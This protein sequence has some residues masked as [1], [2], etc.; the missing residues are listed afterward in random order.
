MMM[1]TPLLPYTLPMTLTQPL[2]TPLPTLNALTIPQLI[3][4]PWHYPMQLNG[5]E[6]YVMNSTP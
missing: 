6:H 4:R 2:P 1:M 5:H 3:L